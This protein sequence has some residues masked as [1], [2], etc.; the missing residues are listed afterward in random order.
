MKKPSKLKNVAASVRDRLL[1]ISRDAGQEYQTLLVRYGI[2]RLLYRLSISEHRQRFVLKGAQL[3]TIWHP[4]PHRITRD[5]DLLGFGSCEVADLIA[6]FRDLCTIVVDDDGLVFDPA[7]VTGEPI[8]AEELYVGVRISF[9]GKIGGAR[10]PMQVDVGFGDS[11]AAPPVEIA[12]P[13]LLEMPEP[14]LRAYRMETTVA[15]KFD[16]V[17]SLGILNSRMKDYFDLW[18]LSKNFSFDGAQLADSIKSTC[19]RRGHTIEPSAPVG[20]TGDFWNDTSRQAVGNAFWKKSVRIDPKLSLQEVVTFTAEFLV[21]PMLAA[22]KGSSFISWWKPG[23][24]WK[25]TGT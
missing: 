24:P 8:R 2:E 19:A 3:F 16:A 15:E 21:P 10:V 22:G 23:G 18:F 4:I 9:L 5:L 7:T 13:S 17:L 1:K 20:L 14:L 25:E 11:L 12:F 6:V